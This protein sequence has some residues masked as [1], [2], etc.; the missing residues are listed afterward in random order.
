MFVLTHHDFLENLLNV[1]SKLI[2]SIFCQHRITKETNWEQKFKKTPNCKQEIT[3]IN[4]ENNGNLQMLSFG[5]NTCSNTKQNDLQT[6]L[7][8]KGLLINAKRTCNMSS[9]I[10]FL[11]KTGIFA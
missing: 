7:I 8:F 2:I 1:R 11:P 10:G 5:Y 9:L 3:K 6:L 4:A